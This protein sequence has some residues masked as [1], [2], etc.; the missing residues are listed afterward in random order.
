MSTGRMLSGRN[1]AMEAD[2]VT[3]PEAVAQRQPVTT[4]IIARQTGVLLFDH[5]LDAAVRSLLDQAASAAGVPLQAWRPGDELDPRRHPLVI[6]AALAHGSRRL[7]PAV[8]HLADEVFPGVAVLL[9]SQETLVQPWI[10]LHGG[11]VT[12]VGAP[13]TPSILTARIQAATEWHMTPGAAPAPAPP[14]GLQRSTWANGRGRAYRLMNGE[15]PTPRI[16]LSPALGLTALAIPAAL[17]GA[18]ARSLERDLIPTLDAW[19]DR[20]DSEHFSRAL[21]MADGGALAHLDT[22][23][24]RWLVVSSAIVT[25]AL[26]SPQRLPGWWNF[27]RDGGQRV[28]IVLAEPGDVLIAAIGLP[29]DG[30]CAPTRLAA[31]AAHGGLALVEHLSAALQHREAACAVAILELLP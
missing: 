25:M 28:R 11:R 16:E 24:G 15:R 31:L 22:N 3:E 4:R 23:A 5:H 20:P 17:C 21:D 14:T 8:A 1:D 9:L 10:L 27:A 2:P 29:E 12:V 19:Q 13:V 6:V 30:E 18:P 26:A 7:P